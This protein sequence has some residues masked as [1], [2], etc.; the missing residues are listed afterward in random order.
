LDE[1]KGDLHKSALGLSGGQQQQLAIGRALIGEPDLLLLD[2]PSEGIQ[3][4]IVQEIQAVIASLKGQ[5]SILLVEQNAR[6]ALGV[7]R[8]GY[9]LELGKV[10]IEGEACDLKTTSASAP[11]IWAGPRCPADRQD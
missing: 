11:R 2:E 9:I 6:K 10:A 4:S 5:L 7:A 3:P 1:V 8:Y